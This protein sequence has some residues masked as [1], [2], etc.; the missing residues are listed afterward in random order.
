MAKSDMAVYP[1]SVLVFSS[2]L[3][4]ITSFEIAKKQN[5]RS[6]VYS[7][8]SNVEEIIQR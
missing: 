4:N 1:E 2:R 3:K 5:I 8:N 6:T 7:H